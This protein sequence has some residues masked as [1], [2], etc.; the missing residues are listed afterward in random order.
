[1]TSP[2][3]YQLLP[4]LSDEEYQALHA[5]IAE[6]GVRVPIDVDEDGTI[7]DGHHR[8]W[9]T[10]DLGIECPRRVVEGLDEQGKRDYARAVNALRR[11]LTIEQR[12]EQVTQMRSEGR[13]VREI[14]RTLGIPRSTVSDDIQVSDPGHLPD[15]VTG[16]DGKT[17]AATR[18]APTP[19]PEMEQ[20]PGAPSDEDL[21]HGHEW[22]QPEG[23]GFEDAVTP[24]PAVPKQ[25]RRPLPEA[26]ADAGRDLTRAAERLAR[27]TEDDRFTKNR[28]QTHHQTPELLGALD[29]LAHLVTAMR[30]HETEASEEA[31]RWWA[32]SLH[33]TSDALRDVAHSIEQEK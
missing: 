20:E 5:D 22:N 15:R 3:P 24:P 14:A 8:A 13:S 10:A 9:I 11:H 2:T 31:R 32:T 7:L 4:R 1:M 33:K 27:L 26:F 16:A 28:P 19:E 18:P 17:Y 21:L 29:H 12:R 6:N 25:K 23:P 30:L